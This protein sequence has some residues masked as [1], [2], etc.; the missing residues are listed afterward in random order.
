MRC[1]VQT[2]V[3]GAAGA[4]FGIYPLARHTATVFVLAVV[5]IAGANGVGSASTNGE[6]GGDVVA[7]AAILVILSN[8]ATALPGLV[9]RLCKLAVQRDQ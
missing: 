5:G 6:P 1:S 3:W 7:T 4:L 2:A 8:T 9:R